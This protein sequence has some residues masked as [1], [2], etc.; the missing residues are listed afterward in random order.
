MAVA[1][2]AIDL[3]AE[4]AASRG[5]GVEL[6]RPDG[7]VP[8][9]PGDPQGLERLFQNLLDNAIKYNREGG[10]VTV[11]I[12]RPRAGGATVIE[13][14]DTGIGIPKDALGRVFERFYRVDKGRARAE[15]GTGLGLAIVKHVAQSAGGKV[16]VASEL[17]AG[18]RVRV[19]LPILGRPSV[20]GRTAG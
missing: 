2:R 8:P 11:R 10:R 1:R 16:E 15:G 5:V 6:V 7:P 3:S 20:T 13:V 18:T 14:A 12:S 9:I 4:R 19:E 17:G